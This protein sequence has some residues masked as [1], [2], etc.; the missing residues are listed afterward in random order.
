MISEE[1]HVLW[2]AGLLA[3][4][5][6]ALF[7]GEFAPP[8][9]GPVAF[10]RDKIPLEVDAMVE[11]SQ[12]LEALARGLNPA[13]AAARRGAAQML[14]LALA[15]DPVNAKA[16]ELMA[17]YQEDRHQPDTDAGRLENIRTRILQ[18][19]TW[20]ETV[21]AGSQ[22]QALAACLKDVLNI[23]DPKHPQAGEIGE[24]AGWV[25]DLSAYETKVVVNND[26][27]SK[28]RP[29]V[30]ASPKRDILLSKA[31]VHTLLWRQSGKEGSSN[32]QLASAPLQMLATKV[33]ES[34]EGKTPFSI[35]IGSG[36]DAGMF[37]STCAMLSKLLNKHH[38]PL[39]P[40]CRISIDS[41]E[42]EQSIQS[43]KLQ[44]ISAAAA[45][46][47]SAAITG[48]EPGAIIIGQIDESGTFKLPTGFWDQL[49]ALGKGG[50][51]RLVLP[52]DAA[53]WLPSLLAM[54]NPGFFLEYEVLL[55]ADFRELLD[56]TA[57]TPDEALAKTTTQFRGI[58][59]RI[60][61]QDVRQYIANRFVRQR[62]GE[63]MQEAP[64]HFSA[65]MLLVQASGNRPILLERMVLA[66]ELRRAIEPLDWIVKKAGLVYSPWSEK[67]E[68]DKPAN[69]SGSN[70]FSSQEISKFSQTR[71]LCRTRVDGLEHH[72]EKNDRE[73]L[74]STRK[75]IDAI[76]NLEKAT[77]TRGYTS[78]VSEA[79]RSACGELI[80]L[81]KQLG[82][83]LA[84]EI[85]EPPSSPNH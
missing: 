42:L 37:A 13:S 36:Q 32:W 60:G 20:L 19:V 83:E 28:P 74:D 45:V 76:R 23:A 15:L 57:K 1:R 69:N 30:V 31:Q 26:A 62:L 59:E 25:P 66:A 50:G 85:G 75:V 5:G 7:A 11:L 33:D 6:V 48:R 71:D 72:A 38:A 2:I 81:H 63:I 16:R 10:R 53:S 9:E 46:L 40:D 27:S 21:A 34:R 24:W 54:E 58:C 17:E 78:V 47:A 80:S 82:K 39:P 84:R 43:R 44:S 41:K 22:G 55:A 29:R 52:A 64:F 61:T 4:M 73:L 18:N 12:Q 8:A 3:S 56:L 67:P 70:E 65:K 79:I 35:V 77:R 49:Q 51:Q 14:A 68:N